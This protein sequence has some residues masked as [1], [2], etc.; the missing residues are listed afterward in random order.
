MAET[1]RSAPYPWRFHRVGGLDQVQLESA[2]DLRNIGR[3]DQKLWV[4]LACPVKGLEI[5]PATL[6]LLDADKDGRVRAP[7]VIAAVKFADARLKDLGDVVKGKDTLPLVDIR[8]DTPEG[9]A[10]LGAARQILTAAGKPEATEITLDD[11]AD[12]SHVFEKTLFNGD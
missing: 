1:L 4:A 2:D 6:A 11:V 9:K 8:E 7:E 10:L 5:D 3:L 12:L